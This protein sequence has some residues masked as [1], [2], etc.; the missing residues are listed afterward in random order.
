MVVNT[1]MSN[2]GLLLVG[3][4]V[5]DTPAMHQFLCVQHKHIHQE[6]KWYDDHT[7]REVVHHLILLNVCEFYMFSHILCG[8]CEESTVASSV[9][10]SNVNT[11]EHNKVTYSLAQCSSAAPM[12]HFCTLSTA[13]MRGHNTLTANT[14]LV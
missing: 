6:C 5:I 9:S 4:V 11:H 2:A 1:V 3:N 7:K 12:T 13:C 8:N 10:C 14:R